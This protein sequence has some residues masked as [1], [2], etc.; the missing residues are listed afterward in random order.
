MQHLGVR[1]EK[2][3]VCKWKLRPHG[4]SW[5]NNEKLN[6]NVEAFSTPPASYV[7][8]VAYLVKFTLRNLKVPV[9]VL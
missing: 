6:L 5:I 9:P 4:A 8:Q 7:V 2:P 1:A 3:K